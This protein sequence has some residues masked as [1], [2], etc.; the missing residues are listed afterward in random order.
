MR[1]TSILFLIFFQITTAQNTYFWASSSNGFW[2][3][4]YNWLI[5]QNGFLN[6]STTYPGQQ[7]TQDTVYISNTGNY[8]IYL[9]VSVT[10]QN[11]IMNSTGSPAIIVSTSSFSGNFIK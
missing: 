8:N 7:S 4:S 1:K 5:F 6:T 11:L 9:N 10:I 3:N 2:G